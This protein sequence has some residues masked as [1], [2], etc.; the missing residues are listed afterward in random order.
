MP[1]SPVAPVPAMSSTFSEPAPDDIPKKK[2]RRRSRSD[3]RLRWPTVVFPLLFLL[4]AGIVTFLVL[5]L[6]GVL[7]FT[8][9]QFEQPPYVSVPRPNQSAREAAEA[10]TIAAASHQRTAPPSSPVRVQTSPVPVRTSSREGVPPIESQDLNVE[11]QLPQTPAIHLDAQSPV[12]ESATSSGAGPGPA[13]VLDL[14]LKATSI[15]ERR[16]Y[17]T[18]S[19][20]APEDLAQS[21]L[22]TPLPEVINI[23]SFHLMADRAERHTEHFYEV[24]F[25]RVPGQRAVPF[26]VQLNDWGDG[27]IRVHADAFIDLYENKIGA[28]A[29]APTEEAQTFHVV[30]DAYKHCFD[31][32]IPDWDKK[33]FLKLRFH[34]RVAPKL[35][36]YFNRNSP[37]AEAI[38]Q[39]NVLPWGESG[40]CTVTVKWNTED[41]QQAYVELIRIDGFT[42]NP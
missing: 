6:T 39:P 13:E 23:R 34:P 41:P 5:E 17:M 3:S 8:S 21:C 2:N 28:F 32:E 37:I 9:P 18:P 1:G 24:A 35:H 38:A 11:G 4:L 10:R 14:F 33:S 42:W 30:A 29:S 16:P 27:D 22:A 15:D 12:N 19:K 26:L 20:R 40:I 7:T 31:E 25:E 36:A